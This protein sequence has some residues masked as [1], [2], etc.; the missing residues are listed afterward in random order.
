[1]CNNNDV[2]PHH[3]RIAMMIAANKTRYIELVAAIGLE[4]TSLAYKALETWYNSPPEPQP[5]VS[6]PPLELLLL[7]PLED[8]PDLPLFPDSVE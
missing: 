7:L 1:M 5:L 4:F 3:F 6:E 8:L 2:T